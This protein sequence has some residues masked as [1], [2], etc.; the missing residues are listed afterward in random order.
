MDPIH[1]KIYTST[2]GWVGGE[3]E[4]K[5]TSAKFSLGLSWGWAWRNPEHFINTDLFVHSWKQELVGNKNT[6]DNELVER[7][8]GELPIGKTS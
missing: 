2:G 4:F 1:V 5:A 6:V 7:Y 3:M 8:I